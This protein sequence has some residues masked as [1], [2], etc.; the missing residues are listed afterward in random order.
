MGTSEK[1]INL[2]IFFTV[3]FFFTSSDQPDARFISWTK[4]ESQT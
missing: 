4:W 1:M 3:A 2:I